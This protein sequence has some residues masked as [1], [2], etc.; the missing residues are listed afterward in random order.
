MKNLS[1]Q[2]IDEDYYTPIR[3]IDTFDNKKNY[4]KYESGGDKNKDLSP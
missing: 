4:F 1:N 3:T 2:S